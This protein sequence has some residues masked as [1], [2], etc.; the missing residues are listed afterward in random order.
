MQPL[1]V[2][3]DRAQAGRRLQLQLQAALVGSRPDDLQLL[4]EQRL[5]V[6]VGRVDGHLPGLD[7][8][9]VQQLL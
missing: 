3:A 8:G 4:L 5:Q 1:G 6:D 7:P 2:G 9:Q